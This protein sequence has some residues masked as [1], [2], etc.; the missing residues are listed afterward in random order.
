MGYRDRERGF[1]HRLFVL[2]MASLAFGCVGVESTANMDSRPDN[3]QRTAVATRILIVGQDLDAIRGYMASDCCIRPDGLTA[4]L[5]LY[6]LLKPGNFGGLGIDANG[7]PLD[8][9]MSWGAGSV[10]AYR[11]AT[12]FGTRDIAIG[13]SITENE[14]PGGLQRVVDGA[15]DA[16]IRQLARFAGLVDG[17]IYL[18]IG[19]EF[20]G[21]WNHG[22]WDHDKYVAAYRR[23]VDVLRAEGA[24]NVEYVLQASAAGVDEIIDGGRE[25]IAQW[26]PGDDYVDWLA[27][28]WFMNPDERSI[29][30]QSNFTP[31][32]PG[33]LADEVLML[34][35][36][37]GKP[38]MIAEASPQAMDLN[39]RFTANHSPLWDGAAASGRTSM[40]DDEIWDYWFAPLFAYMKKHR[41]VIHA[42]AYINVD[43]DS[44]AMWGPP[45]ANGYWGDSRLETNPE[46]AKRFN[47]AIENWK[48][49]E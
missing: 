41:D 29:V 19:Y 3:G 10:S 11:T 34:A 1:A 30:P 43:W 18:R 32:T 28:S 37:K 23:I 17:R 15:H 48:N 9:E 25:N 49:E 20:D 45:Y 38:L 24:E 26:Y 7:E 46:I 2:T 5:D 33:E 21:A 35:R 40:T 44:Q 14:H 16:E 8:F 4:Y 22:Y 47:A 36:E 6:N 12:E 31:L 27:L 39:E 13:L 42:L